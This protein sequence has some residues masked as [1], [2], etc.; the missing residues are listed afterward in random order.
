MRVEKPLFEQLSKY[1][2]NGTTKKDRGEGEPFTPL[3]MPVLKFDGAFFMKAA[4]DER[5][6]EG[7]RKGRDLNKHVY[8]LVC[9][10]GKTP[11]ELT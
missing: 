5:R 6:R 3:E 7:R 10:L 2:C 4:R 9:F 1:W 11:I 8:L